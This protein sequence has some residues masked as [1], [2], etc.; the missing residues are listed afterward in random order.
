[1]D[2]GSDIKRNL[3]GGRSL[4]A[5]VLSSLAQDAGTR[6]DWTS[7]WLMML[8]LRRKTVIMIIWRFSLIPFRRYSNR[9]RPA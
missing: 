5:D 4:S 9:L 7:F 2:R 3:R 1:M 6:H 8:P